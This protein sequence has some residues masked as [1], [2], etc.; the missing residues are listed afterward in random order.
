MTSSIVVAEQEA[1]PEHPQL[2]GPDRTALVAALRTEIEKARPFSRAERTLTLI[3]QAALE[4]QDAP[5]GYRVID[6]HGAPRLHAASEVGEG[7]PIT[8]SDLLAELR[9]RHPGLF[10][11]PEPVAPPQ[12]APEPRDSTLAAGQRRC[13]PRR[14]GSWAPN[15]SAPG[16]WPSNPRSRAGPSPSRRRA[17]SRPCAVACVARRRRHRS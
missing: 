11:P 12:P 5:P 2:D 16:P 14:L 7:R 1:R 8:I 6:R 10:R 15:L 17:P 3:A 4:P 13:E 9:E